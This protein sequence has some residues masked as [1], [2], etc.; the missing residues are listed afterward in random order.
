MGHFLCVHVSRL[1]ENE[2]AL[3][4]L[5]VLL[6]FLVHAGVGI[7]LLHIHGCRQL[8]RD[9]HAFLVPGGGAVLHDQIPLDLIVR[10]AAGHGDLVDQHMEVGIRIPASPGAPFADLN[11]ELRFLEGFI[12]LAEVGVELERDALPAF[13]AHGVVD[14]PAFHA[15]TNQCFL[16]SS[17]RPALLRKST[18]SAI[19]S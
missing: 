2:V 1:L 17:I 19:M 3:E 5:A 4:G 15:A 6:D 13:H 12:A 16:Y 9:P 18:N 11:L 8:E 14:D 7:D 10:Q